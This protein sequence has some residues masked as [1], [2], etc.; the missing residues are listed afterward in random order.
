MHARYLEQVLRDR[1]MPVAP[2]AQLEAFVQGLAPAQEQEMDERLRRLAMG[3]ERAH[4]GESIL[5]GI[6]KAAS[7]AAAA[8]ADDAPHSQERCEPAALEGSHEGNPV[9]SKEPA[10]KLPREVLETLRRHGLHVY[11]KTAALKVELATLRTGESVGAVQYTVQLDAARAKA[12]GYDWRAKIPFQFTRRELPLLAAALLGMRPGPLKIENHGPNTDKHFELVDQQA[13][14]FVKVRLSG[15]PTIALPVGPADVFAW[16][17]L[18]LVALHLNR[19]TISTDG[20]LALL[21][22]IGK[23]AGS[24]E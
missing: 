19:P 20:H 21:R 24:H 22:R 5:D 13:H 10:G 7:S 18:C 3:V 8:P 16:G 9:R 6:R 14:L 2:L 1:G 15:G 4:D 12:D 17:E 11:A 23:M